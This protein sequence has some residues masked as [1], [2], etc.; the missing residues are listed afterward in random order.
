MSQLRLHLLTHTSRYSP[1][2]TFPI[3]CPVNPS[4]HTQ[5][6]T[7]LN[8]SSYSWS[9]A[10]YGHMHIE[11]IDFP[12]EWISLT[13]AKT[14]EYN[15]VMAIVA[16]LTSYVCVWSFKGFHEITPFVLVCIS[17]QHSSVSTLLQ[18]ACNLT[19]TPS[20]PIFT[21]L[22][23]ILIKIHNEPKTYSPIP[24]SKQNSPAPLSPSPFYLHMP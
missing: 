7:Q 17:I 12:R 3:P 5:L 24:Y 13:A 21:Y 4:L 19:D 10:R 6:M 2:H 22:C 16:G 23:L 8:P 9:S 14:A 20:T 18:E 1:S 11:Q 15:A